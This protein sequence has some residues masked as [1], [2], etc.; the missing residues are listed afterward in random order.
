MI[1]RQ[2]EVAYSGWFMMFTWTVKGYY[3]VLR[4]LEEYA[5]T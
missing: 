2:S 1:R 4:D 3:D 5:W